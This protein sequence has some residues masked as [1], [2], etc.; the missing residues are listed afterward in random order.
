MSTFDKDLIIK[1]QDKWFWRSDDTNL[2]TFRVLSSE[3]ELLE[4]VKPFLKNNKVVV[5]AGGNCGMQVVK[6]AEFFETVYTFEPDPVNFYCLVNNLPYDNVVKFQCCLGNSHKMISMNPLKD[7]IGGFFVNETKGNI[8][9]L[10]VDD[11]NLSEC[12]FIQ[13][14][15]EG[16]QLFALQGAINT[17]K[18][19]KPVISIELDWVERYNFTHRDIKSFLINLGYEKVDSYTSDHIYVYKE[20]SFSL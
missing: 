5:Q 18:K 20:L 19:F 7:E 10:K 16:Y 6:F 2:K 12:A 3:T 14:D 1:I 13:L 9:T 15:V 17:I 11:L 8:P 4:K